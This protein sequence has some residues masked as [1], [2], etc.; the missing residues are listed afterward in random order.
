[1]MIRNS[2][3]AALQLPSMTALERSS[4]MEDNLRFIQRRAEATL[5]QSQPEDI[6][7]LIDEAVQIGRDKESPSTILQ[8]AKLLASLHKTGLELSLNALELHKKIS[9]VVPDNM[10][11]QITNLQSNE[12]LPTVKE[13][14]SAISRYVD[15]LG[16]G[17]GD[18]INGGK[19]DAGASHLDRKL[20][21]DLSGTEDVD[22][23]RGVGG[24][25]E[26]GKSED[27]PVSVKRESDD[28]LQKVAGV[29]GSEKTSEVIDSEGEEAGDHDSD[30]GLIL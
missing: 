9:S 13:A 30:S 22:N 23:G 25:S 2:K 27:N 28:P 20:L 10:N 6:R 19:P 14:K 29:L 11:V 8:A 17:P 18:Q 7:A 1:M 16:G 21:E 5:E 12:T 26:A 4:T 24:G 15:I 3:A